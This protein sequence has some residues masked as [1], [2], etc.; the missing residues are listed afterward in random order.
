MPE[1]TRRFLLNGDPARELSR[2]KVKSKR[3][4]EGDHYSVD[5]VR[6][7]ILVLRE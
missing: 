1:T 7:S 4:N 2:F 3:I 5:V 6:R